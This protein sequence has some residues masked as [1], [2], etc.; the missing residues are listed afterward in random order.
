MRSLWE[1]RRPACGLCAAQPCL[2]K[3]SCVNPCLIY[4]VDD[5]QRSMA[6][7]ATSQI[8]FSLV[9]DFRVPR[10]RFPKKY[11]IFAKESNNTYHYDLYNKKRTCPGLLSRHRL[12]RRPK[13]A[14]PVD[15][16]QRRT[17]GTSRRHGLHSHTTPFHSTTGEA[18]LSLPR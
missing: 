9:S 13:E 10:Q 2:F 1:R 15:S 6:R 7:C 5:L 16:H 11:I 12:Q 4:S 14:Q 17:L 8:I 18:T 3:K